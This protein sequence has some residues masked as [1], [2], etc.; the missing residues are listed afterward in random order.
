MS[1]VGLK[2]IWSKNVRNVLAHHH[3][4][5]IY[6]FLNPLIYFGFGLLFGEKNAV[7]IHPLGPCERFLLCSD[8]SQIKEFAEKGSDRI[9]GDENN[10]LSEPLIP[11]VCPLCMHESLMPIIELQTTNILPEYA[12]DNAAHRIIYKNA[13]GVGCIGRGWISL[14]QH[15]RSTIP[16]LSTQQIQHEMHIKCCQKVLRKSLAPDNHAWQILLSHHLFHC[17]QVKISLAWSTNTEYF[18]VS[19]PSTVLDT[20]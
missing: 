1:I 10:N 6:G 4:E 3:S 15:H 2:H 8:I 19:M 12:L 20:L 16:L 5:R 13:F 18:H 14:S 11:A 9:I 17:P 7:W